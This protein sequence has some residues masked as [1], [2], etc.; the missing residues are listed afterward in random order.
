MRVRNF[1]FLLIFLLLFCLEMGSPD[2][3]ESKRTN[4]WPVTMAILYDNNPYDHR[5]K[6]AWGFSCLIEFEGKKILFDTGGDGRTLLENMEILNKDPKAINIV[7]LSHI[8][9]DHTGGLG[10]L[11]REKSNLKIYVP[12]SFPQD[13]GRAANGYGATV[14]RVNAPLEICQGLHSTGEMGHGIKE[15]SLLIDTF[16]GMVLV[17]GCAHPGILVV[18]KRAKTMA[19]RNIYMVVG[20]WHLSSAGEREIKGIIDAFLT[21]GIQK[22]APCHCTGDGAMAMFKSEYGENFITTGVGRIIKI[23]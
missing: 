17:T 23:E 6:T 21:M 12:E 10:S 4:D 8:H 5:L 18:I 15:Q 11:L 22:V 7:I 1:N 9:G 13:F 14:A 3:S 20:G 2:S 19:R 16:K